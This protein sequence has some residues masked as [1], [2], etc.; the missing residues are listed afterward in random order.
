MKFC[1]CRAP[2]RSPMWG[3]RDCYLSTITCAAYRDGMPVVAV[4]HAS[5][6]GAADLVQGGPRPLS[7]PAAGL[8]AAVDLVSQ[9]SDL[10]R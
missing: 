2:G 7:S 10:R 3:A 4:T 5:M 6:A 8:A 9:K 1:L